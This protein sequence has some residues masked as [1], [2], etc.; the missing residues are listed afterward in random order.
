MPL[1][2]VGKE[3]SQAFQANINKSDSHFLTVDTQLVIHRRANMG[4]RDPEM[5]TE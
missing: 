1:S 2:E 4:A 5:L 3:G